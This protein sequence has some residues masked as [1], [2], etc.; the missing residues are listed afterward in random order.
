MPADDQRV[1]Y[2]VV[3]L[4]GTP[5]RKTVLLDPEIVPESQIEVEGQRWTVADVRSAVVRPQ[6]ICIYAD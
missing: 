2:D 3:L 6:L 5:L 4:A 1:A